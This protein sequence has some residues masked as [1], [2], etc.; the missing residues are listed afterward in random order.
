MKKMVLL[1]SA[2]LAFCLFAVMGYFLAA[3]ADALA[4]LPISNQIASLDRQNNLVL[5]H[6]DQL[7]TGEPV[8]QSVWVTI[9]FRSENQTSLTFV[10]LY[11]NTDNAKDGEA[12]GK[13]FG[14][15]KDG[16]PVALFLKRLEEQG[17]HS[18]GYLLV[19][20]AGMQ[21]A[22]AWVKQSAQKVNTSG[23]GQILEAGCAVLATAN[24]NVPAFDWG[25][26]AGH[27]RTDL[28]FDSILEEWDQLT[29]NNPP[30]RC[31]LATN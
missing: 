19:D 13:A 23:D 17:I 18:S 26:F 8:L 3:R 21:Q 5:I 7:S 4:R 30:L 11:P 27:L 9:R 16:K 15:D 14:I 31:E 22:A 2:V 28:A 25:I 10:Q 6:V 20:D 1:L 29:S 24:A 12:L